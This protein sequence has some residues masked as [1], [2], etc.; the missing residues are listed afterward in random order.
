MDRAG[1]EAKQ[2]TAKSILELEKTKRMLADAGNKVAVSQ[3]SLQQSEEV[4]RIRKNRFAQ[5]LEKTTDLLAAESLVLQKDM[6]LLQAVFEYN[7]SQQYLQFLT[8]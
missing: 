7:F 1:A 3:L 5:G 2:Y 8:R 6:E 4:Y